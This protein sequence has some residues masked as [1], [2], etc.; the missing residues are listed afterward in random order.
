M[1]LRHGTED[2]SIYDQVVNQ[3][4]YGL[5]DSFSV[6][7]VIVDLGA[8]CGAFMWACAMR[9]AGQIWSVEPDL[10]NYATL[11]RNVGITAEHFRET[12]LFPIHAAMSDLPNVL[13]RMQP[14]NGQST[15]S[16][17]LTCQDEGEQVPSM[18]LPELL[19]IIGRPVRLLKLDI[20][21]A[22]LPV[23]NATK[24]LS[25]V[26][27]VIGEIHYCISL[28]GRTHPTDDWLRATMDRLGFD[29][30]IVPN[31]F[32]DPGVLGAWRGRKK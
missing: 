12:Q 27:E 11:L 5:P 18:S 2:A 9:G 20:E 16:A 32:I 31:K 3:N 22:E 10:R 14:R 25:M 15:A 30:E 1:H 7:D 8:N 28:D 13:L 19:H 24:D 29:C 23:L 26:Q 21:G 6:C 4:E 17:R